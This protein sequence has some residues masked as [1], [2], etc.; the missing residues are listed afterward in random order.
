MAKRKKRYTISDGKMLLLLQEAEEGGYIVTSPIE[1]E[2][3]TEAETIEEAFRNA[4]D[5]VKAL[6]QARIKSNR[7]KK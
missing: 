1:P 3:I 6:K 4:N 7:K 5:A 2:L